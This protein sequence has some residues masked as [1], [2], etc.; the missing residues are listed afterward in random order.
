MGERKPS[1]TLSRFL[2]MVHKK[3][4]D[5]DLQLLLYHE[6]SKCLCTYKSYQPVVI[7]YRLT[8]FGLSFAVCSTVLSI[9]L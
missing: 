7:C 5:D 3:A 2:P 1:F 4:S 9:Y 6:N 8:I